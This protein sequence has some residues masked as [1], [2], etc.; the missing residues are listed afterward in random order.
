[1]DEELTMRT[2]TAISLPCAAGFEGGVATRYDVFH[3]VL[4]ALGAPPRTSAALGRERA[5]V[6][7][8]AGLNAH[9]LKDIGAPS[10]MIANALMRDASP[11]LW[12]LQSGGLR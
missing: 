10:W 11:D 9:L 6:E 12:L 7:A 4:A 2:H 3:R 1:M 5:H 8:L